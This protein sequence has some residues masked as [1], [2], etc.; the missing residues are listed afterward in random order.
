MTA[1]QAADYLGITELGLARLRKTGK[2][3]GFILIPGRSKIRYRPSALV[4]W[5]DSREAASMAAHHVA[6]AKR[7]AGA[8]RQREA[9]AHARQS[10]WPKAVT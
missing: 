10:R 6:D 3:P 8:A 9:A 1:A 5:L 2:G 4:R 7:A